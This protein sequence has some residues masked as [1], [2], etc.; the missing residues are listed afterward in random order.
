MTEQAVT[1]IVGA[2]Y[3]RI[4]N[5]AERG[6]LSADERHPALCCRHRLGRRETNFRLDC[7]C[8]QTFGSRTVNEWLPTIRSISPVDHVSHLCS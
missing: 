3:C 8:H 2:V 1:K 7:R 6:R 4:C 5:D